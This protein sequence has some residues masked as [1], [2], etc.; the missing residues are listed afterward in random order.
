M[1]QDMGAP[2]SPSGSRAPHGAASVSTADAAS[3]PNAW[4]EVE[5]EEGYP[6]AEDDDFKAWDGLPL[7]FGEAARFVLRELPKAAENCC[8]YCDVS[9]VEEYGEMLKRIHFSTGGWSGAESLI[10]FIESRFDTRHFMESWRRGGHY[11]FEIPASAIEA[12]RGETEGLDA[13]HESAP[14]RPNPSSSF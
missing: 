3:I 1:E 4:P 14:G 12:R 5:W 13:K 11:V 9:E 8:A 2:A 7:D 10:A 6:T